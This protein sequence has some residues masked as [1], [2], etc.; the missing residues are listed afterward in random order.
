MFRIIKTV[1]M[2]IV[3]V[4]A[5]IGFMSVGG[6]KLIED[7]ISKFVDQSREARLERTKSVGDF[8]GVSDEFDI[9]KAVKLFGYT[10]VIS[11][12]KASGQ[13][14]VVLESEKNPILTE[15]DITS[16]ELVHKINSMSKKLSYKVKI[17]D[18]RITGRG[19]IYSYGKVIPYARFTANVEKLPIKDLEGIVAA[20]DDV[21]NEKG[22]MMISVSERGKYSQLLATEF[23]RKIKV[24]QK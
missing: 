18:L 1:F 20:A 13:K 23:F 11:E 2:L 15:N 5:V 12:H 19:T 7:T 24:V 8:S 21:Q 6:D 3:F 4:F 22:R 14:L 10:A 17:S 16:G 9:D